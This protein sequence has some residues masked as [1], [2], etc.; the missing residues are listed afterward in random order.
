D[1][2]NVVA[3]SQPT[4]SLHPGN[5]PPASVSIASENSMSSGPSFF[6]RLFGGPPTPPAPVGRRQQ[7]RGMFTR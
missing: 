2:E 3:H 6:E 7:P 1:L 4:Y 5:T